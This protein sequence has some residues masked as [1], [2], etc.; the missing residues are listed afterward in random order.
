MSLTEPNYCGRCGL[1][2]IA[3]DADGVCEECRWEERENVVP[4]TEAEAA[5]PI[6]D[7]RMVD[8]VAF[9]FDPALEK[10]AVWGRGEEVIWSPGE[11]LL[12]VGPDGTGKTT[13]TQRLALAR[14]GV[15]AELLGYPVEPAPA[16][17]LYVAADRPK[18]AGRSLRRMLLG[19]PDADLL[20]VEK[21]MVVWKGP[22]PFDLVRDP[23]R[24]A[25]WV[26]EHDASDVFLDSLGIVVPGLAKDEVGAAIAQAWASCAAHE[27]E[28]VA[29]YHPRKATS[30]HP[31]P[32]KLEDVYGSRWITSSS[33]SVLSLWG[34]PGDPVV[35][36]RHLKPPS[37]PIGPF[38]VEF[39]QLAGSVSVSEGTD[40]LAI[41]RGSP[42]GL[43]AKEGGV[44]MEGVNE[45]A[46]EKRAYRKLEG[47]VG[48]GLAYRREGRLIRGPIHE[49]DR[50]Y[51]TT[52]S[53]GT[54]TGTAS[55]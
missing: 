42:N 23:E 9:A 18:Q 10:P 34:Q 25:S 4:I 31:K 22:L 2:K 49:P 41:L 38:M 47:Y 27:V 19:L 7:G 26:V 5:R 40:L 52:S 30:D 8:G 33:G 54:L 1:D 13:T 14:V 6:A 37:E 44:Y 46:R 51:P 53:T 39:D 35:E 32:N 17:V 12:V 48:K 28:I 55:S 16:K 45:K 15:G 43:S 21:R 29:P 11:A 24:L 50:Y 36:L 3:L 20:R